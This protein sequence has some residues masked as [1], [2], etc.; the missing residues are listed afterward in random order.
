VAD[1]RWLFEFVEPDGLWQVYD[2][3][4]GW[5]LESKLPTKGRL[6]K[7][8]VVILASKDAQLLDKCE[9]NHVH[10]ER[11]RRVSECSH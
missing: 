11:R 7:Y 5:I 3:F 2:V 4:E 9:S 1:R 10:R 8:R 6:G